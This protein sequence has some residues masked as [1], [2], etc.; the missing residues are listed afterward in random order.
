MSTRKCITCRTI[1]S[2]DKFTMY[3]RKNGEYH[4][5]TI[6]KTCQ[7]A[8]DSKHAHKDNKN[9]ESYVNGVMFR[10]TGRDY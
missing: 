2:L 9:V 8:R 6:C 1:L 7:R 4:Y 3:K 10:L 5:R